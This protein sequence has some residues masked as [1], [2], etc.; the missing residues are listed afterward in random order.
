MLRHVTPLQQVLQTDVELTAADS[1]TVEVV[2]DDEPLLGSDEL[3]QYISE[4]LAKK[5]WD[6]AGRSV[7]ADDAD[8]QQ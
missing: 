2:T 1:R 6:G 4:L 3:V 5:Q 8:V 7:D